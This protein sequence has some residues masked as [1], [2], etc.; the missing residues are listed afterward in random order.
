MSNQ[1]VSA[2]GTTFTVD[3]VEVG[4]IEDYTLFDGVVPDVPHRPMSGPL[5]FLPGLPDYGQVRIRLYRNP[6]DPGQTKMDEV[7]AQSR[8]VNCTITLIDGTARTF[9]GYV[10]QLPLMGGN[11]NGTGL[12]T[13]VIKVAGPPQ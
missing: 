9:P 1:V 8:V 10:K 7:R 11:I 13:A 3:G 4:G 2:D 5:S 12:V 6:A